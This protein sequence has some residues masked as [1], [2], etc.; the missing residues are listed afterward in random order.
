[1]IFRRRRAETNVYLPWERKRGI[2][3]RLARTRARQVVVASIVIGVVLLLRRR[4]EHHASVRAT[5]ASLTT[6]HRA[7]GAFRADHSGECPK[8]W[9]D[10]VAQ[11]Y[12]RRQPIDAWG[13]PLRM[14]CPG[15]RDPH[16]VD[17]LSDGPD[18]L[19]YG[20]DRVE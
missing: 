16:G 13:R 19:P 9:G 14:V 4:E 5:R 11:G 1:M 6:A 17:V 10:L 12:A 20:L 7:L 2:V 18:G 15:R 3:G 8:Q